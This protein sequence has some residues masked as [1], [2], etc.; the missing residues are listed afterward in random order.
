MRALTFFAAVAALAAPLALA[1]PAR[2]QVPP[3]GGGLPVVD[4]W[5]FRQMAMSGNIYEVAA[6]HIAME[7]ARSPAVRAFGAMLVADHT[8]AAQALGNG[9]IFRDDLSQLMPPQQQA[10]ATLE[11]APPGAFDLV[12]LNQQIAVH[13]MTMAMYAA[14]AQQGFEPFL[15][16]AAATAIP[17]LQHHLAVAETLRA[18]LLARR[19][20][21]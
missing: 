12:F 15:R 6:G 20:V 18:R 2:A 3:V 14:Y 16:Q 11:N 9:M 4:T 5:Q 1:A 10:I 7:R 21:S 8:R 13:R 19:A 17:M